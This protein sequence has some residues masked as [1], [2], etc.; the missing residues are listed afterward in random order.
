MAL[1]DP[2]IIEF[3]RLVDTEES[4]AEFAREHGL[5]LSDQAHDSACNGGPH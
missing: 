2:G 1:Q 4:A 3:A 5:L